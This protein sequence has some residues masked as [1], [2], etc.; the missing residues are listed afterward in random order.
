M[1]TPSLLG[2]LSMLKHGVVQLAPLV[3]LLLCNGWHLLKQRLHLSDYCL[4]FCIFLEPFVSAR[5]V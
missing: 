2:M 5:R 1:R 4:Y 3:R